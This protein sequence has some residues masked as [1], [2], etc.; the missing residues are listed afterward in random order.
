MVPQDWYFKKSYIPKSLTNFDAV[1][2]DGFY[3]SG[4]LCY[5]DCS[6]A[7]LENCGIGA[8]A[9]S[10][11]LCASSIAVMLIDFAIGLVQAITLVLTFGASSSATEVFT[12]ARDALN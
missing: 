11:G 6:K 4:A 7:G 1:C 2:D 5:R 3:L 9:G 12:V 10:G 8:C